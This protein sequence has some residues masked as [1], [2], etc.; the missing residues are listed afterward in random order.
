MILVRLYGTHRSNTKP[1]LIEKNP[2][3]PIYV[4]RTYIFETPSRLITECTREW[5]GKRSFRESGGAG[6]SLIV[7]LCILLSTK[8]E[9]YETILSHLAAVEDTKH[10][11]PVFFLY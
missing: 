3:R 7:L 5:F 1:K 6:N 9:K 11:N 2:T 10:F 4:R 8:S